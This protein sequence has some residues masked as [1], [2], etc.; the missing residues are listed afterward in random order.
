MG[1]YSHASGP[2][3]R[4]EKARHVLALNI[5]PVDTESAMQASNFRLIRLSSALSLSF[6]G[7]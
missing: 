4:Y 7:S 2:K 6:S 1:V 5:H 3:R